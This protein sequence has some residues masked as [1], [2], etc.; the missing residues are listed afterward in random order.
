MENQADSESQGI[1][2]ASQSPTGQPTPIQSQ[3][4]INYWMMSTLILGVLLLVMLGVNL[5]GL[6]IFRK[7]S[8][9]IITPPPPEPP[10]PPI[11]SLSSFTGTVKTGAQL[12]EVKS[13]CAEG[14]YLVADEGRELIAGTGTKMLLLRQ[15]DVSD[16]PPMLSNP[17]YVGK[18][19][20]V[21]GKYPAAEVFC[22]A[23]MCG[24]EDYILVE[25]INEVNVRP[26]RVEGR[27]DCLNHKNKTG[28][29]TAECTIGIQT[30][31]NQYYQLAFD[32]LGEFSDEIVVGQEVVITGIFTPLQDSQYDSLGS[33][34]VT[35][36][37]LLP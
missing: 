4:G 34:E 6:G 3:P 23:L 13:Y 8:D 29:Q 27:V 32:P 19:V 22:Q 30:R 18:R 20:E 26:I 28:G 31:D 36:V 2:P 37:E 15:P 17:Q 10:T 1:R 24:C 9:V 11:S 12:G 14:L 33:I 7:N 25:S 5:S 21:A 16:E 35:A